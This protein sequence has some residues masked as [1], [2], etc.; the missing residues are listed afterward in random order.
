MPYNISKVTVVMEVWNSDLTW[1]SPPQYV[2]RRISF[3]VPASDVAFYDLAH[4]RWSAFSE[5][6][7]SGGKQFNE[8]SQDGL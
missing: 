5:A 1:G 6:M 2:K 7:W 3:D 4:E 8:V